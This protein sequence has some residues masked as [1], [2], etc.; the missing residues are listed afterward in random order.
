MLQRRQREQRAVRLAARANI[1]VQAE[2]NIPAAR[3]QAARLPV[4]LAFIDNARLWRGLDFGRMN[5]IC[6]SC[7]ARHWIS[8]RVVHGGLHHPVF[9][10]CC[11][12]GDVVLNRLKE[13]PEP[14]HT[15][16]TS[17]E[18]QARDFRHN[19][20]HWNNVLCFTSVRF[21]MDDS[22]TAQGGGVRVFQIHGELYHLHGPL[23]PSGATDAQY[24]QC[25]LFDPLYATQARNNRFPDL[26]HD[27]ICTLSE[28]FHQF[29]PFAR[30]FKTA[31]E[32][33]LNDQQQGDDLQIILNPQKKL[34]V[35]ILSFPGDTCS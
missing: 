10:G 21:N 25:Y 16:F 20:R 28:M 14:L 3:P 8:E 1:Q 17:M 13:P 26:D 31:G 11:K 12:K 15:L 29:S 32:R 19:I 7:K 33:L 30:V 18:R 34:I 5:I 23:I 35:T 2:R 27:L 6:S 9:E 4:P 22:P 24:A